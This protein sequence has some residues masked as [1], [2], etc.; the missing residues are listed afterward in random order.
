MSAPTITRTLNAPVMSDE[1]EAA[2][3]A[4]RAGAHLSWG[5][6]FRV[7]D[8]ELKLITRDL[9][10]RPAGLHPFSTLYKRL[11]R[12]QL[13]ALMAGRSFT[14]GTGTFQGCCYGGKLVHLRMSAASHRLAHEGLVL[15]NDPYSQDGMWTDLPV[16][17][18]RGAALD[19]FNDEDFAFFSQHH[20][21]D[22]RSDTVRPLTAVDL[23]HRVCNTCVIQATRGYAQ[24]CDHGRPAKL[25]PDCSSEKV[26]RHTAA[27]AR[28]VSQVSAL[29][30]P[31]TSEAAPK[32]AELRKHPNI[33]SVRTEIRCAVGQGVKPRAIG[34]AL[35]WSAI[36][37]S[38]LIA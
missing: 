34:V 4:V 10:G 17:G 16:C 13:E 30:G 25:C 11:D 26:A 14:I 18:R 28:V 21:F 3:A 19:A 24:A 15:Y 23:L 2:Y 33:D 29:L 7:Y 8:S 35:G 12:G 6:W 22:S 9:F 31:W 38:A 32:V 1:V 20:F 27:L 5:D 37:L 36:T